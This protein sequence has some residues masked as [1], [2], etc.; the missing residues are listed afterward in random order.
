MFIVVFKEDVMDDDDFEGLSEV[1]WLEFD[2]NLCDFDFLV[3]EGCNFVYGKKKFFYE[4]WL[5][6]SSFWNFFFV[7]KLF[8]IVLIIVNRRYY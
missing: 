6:N 8:R 3:V 2:D 7:L 5:L 1:V 4:C